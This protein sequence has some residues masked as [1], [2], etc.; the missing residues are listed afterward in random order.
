MAKLRMAH[1]STHGACKHAWR[2]QAAWAKSVQHNRGAFNKYK[3]NS[4]LRTLNCSSSGGSAIL[5]T[6]G[7]ASFTV[8]LYGF[9]TVKLVEMFFNRYHNIDGNITEFTS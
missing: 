2:T 3:N 5:R 7:L 4:M 9:N 1:A 8:S 6:Q